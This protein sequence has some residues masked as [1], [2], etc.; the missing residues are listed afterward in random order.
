MVRI[1]FLADS[2]LG[3]DLP[4]RPRVAR[5]RRGHDFLANHERALAPALRGE[6]DLVVHGGDVF[7]RS[8]VPKTLAH[9]AYATLSRIAERIPVVVVPGNHERSRLPFRTVLSSR[10][11]VFDRP[12]TFV[13]EA[14]GARVALAGFPYERRGVGRSF[15]SLVRRTGWCPDQADISLLCLHH[16]VEGATVGPGD[17]TFRGGEDVIRG[18]DIPAGFAAA[19][20]GH[21]HRHQVL[22]QDLRGAALGAPVLY[23]GSVERTSLAEIDEVKGFLRVDIEDGGA[24]R[25]RFEALP[26]RPMIVH[27][28]DVD[29][30]G[31]LDAHVHDLASGLPPDAV[32]RIRLR[33]E[34]LEEAW[35]VLSAARL[36][37][38]VPETMN[39]D[40]TPRPVP[41]ASGRPQRG[42][43]G[44]AQL[45]LL[46]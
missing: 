42:D 46:G 10:V 20:S 16:C 26:A 24:L 33:G 13:V 45:E 37:R 34:S 43:G 25:W 18:R 38:L 3:F 29:T 32:L 22:T 40:V 9:Q 15:E 4:V 21:I 12:R 39:V 17:F 6:V 11:R 44:R 14:G 23:P 5:R 30:A 36:R 41:P 2:H 1:L 31:A 8:R 28:L 35:R 7:H 27:D 19:F